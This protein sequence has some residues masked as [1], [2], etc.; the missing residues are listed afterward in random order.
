MKKYFLFLLLVFLQFS[1]VAQFN[2]EKEALIKKALSNESVKN[3]FVQSSGGS[4]SVSGV[5]NSEARIEVYVYPNNN[6]NDLSKEEIQQRL[7]EKYDLVIS[8]ANNKLTATA[9]S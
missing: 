6:K 8:I 1:V 2:P 3:V 9:K 7:N 5:A 4:I